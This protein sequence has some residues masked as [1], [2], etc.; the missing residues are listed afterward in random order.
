[1]LSKST[2]FSTCKQYTKIQKQI[3]VDYIICLDNINI[4]L[5]IEF[6]VNIANYFLSF[7]SRSGNQ[8][9]FRHFYNR[10][11]EL[12]TRWQISIAIACKKVS[13]D[14]EILKLYF[15]KIK[16]VIDEKS[17]QIANY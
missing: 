17:I 9:W 5:T 8:Y 15:K 12:K 16:I 14:I 6:V 13:L 7:D 11:L 3:I 1:M 4:L 2:R 10:Y